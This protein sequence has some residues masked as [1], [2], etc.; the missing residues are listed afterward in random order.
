MNSSRTALLAV[1]ATVLIIGAGTSGS[2]DLEALYPGTDGD[3]Y[4]EGNNWISGTP[5]RSVLWFEPRIRGYF[6]QH[7]WAPEDPQGDCH[8]DRFRWRNGTLRYLW[9]DNECDGQDIRTR[10]RP[11]V[12]YMPAVWDGGDWLKF[13]ESRV[14]HHVDGDLVRSGVTSWT[15]TVRGWVDLQPGRPVVWI[16]VELVTVWDGEPVEHT[17][18]WIEDL[19]LD[20]EFGLARHAGGNLNGDGN[21]DV[22]FQTWQELPRDDRT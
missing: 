6:D 18:H 1:L 20:P 15:S 4:L 9:T 10:Y 21:W 3:T 14:T 22:W 11:A 7:N 12:T 16:R 13:G 8:S 5:K 17:T 2:V 19:Y